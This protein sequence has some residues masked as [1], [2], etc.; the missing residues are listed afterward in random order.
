M[1]PQDLGSWYM[2]NGA[3]QMVPFSAFARG[4]WTYGSP[5]LERYNGL[6]S[7]EILGTPASGRSTGEAMA[8]M[9][10]LAKSSRR[11]IWVNPL[12]R[13]GDFAAKAGVP[14]AVGLVGGGDFVQKLLTHQPSDF[15]EMI[16]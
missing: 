11:V 16:R 6:S 14:N 5:K 15:I 3:G 13:F 1:L 12:L 2:R 9:E 8:E 7:V 10:R 4:E